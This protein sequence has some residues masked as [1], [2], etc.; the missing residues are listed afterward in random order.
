MK[1]QVYVACSM[2]GR[3]QLELIKE[4]KIITHLLEQAGF[5]VFHPVLEE[6]LK[7]THK[8]LTADAVTLPPK[9]ALDKWAIR[10]SIALIDA[11]ADMKSEGR[12]HEVGL[13]RYNYWR[14][15]IRISPR[16]AGGFFSIANLEDDC[17][18]ATPDE[19]VHLL[20]HRFGTRSK[21]ILWRLSMLNR[22]LPRFVWEQLRGFWL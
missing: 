11:A 4:A 9:W 13:M 18:V 21:R 8:H 17:I 14:P 6:H 15:V 20:K 7:H 1:P 5:K 19:A 2:T 10:N 16:H 12:E 3:D 22:C